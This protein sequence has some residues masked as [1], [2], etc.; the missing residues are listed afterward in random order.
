MFQPRLAKSSAVL[1]LPSQ[2]LPWSRGRGPVVYHEPRRRVPA[3]DVEHGPQMRRDLVQ[4][5][6][7]DA[8]AVAG[9][10]Q[11]DHGPQPGQVA[12]RT[13][14]RLRWISA[15]PVSSPSFRTRAG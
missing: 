1:H 10:G 2:L 4:D 6:A 5:D 3:D 7:P 8:P 9:A 14:A 13:P 15:G 11:E 12:V